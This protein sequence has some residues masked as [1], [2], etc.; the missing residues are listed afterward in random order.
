MPFRAGLPGGKAGVK[1]LDKTFLR[2]IMAHP[3]GGGFSFFLEQQVEPGTIKKF[4][5]IASSENMEK[6]I[7]D[8]P[9]LWDEVNAGI[10]DVLA[11]GRKEGLVD[12]MHSLDS[13]WKSWE[14]KIARSKNDPGLIGKAVPALIKFKMSK[15]AL[16]KLFLA[17]STGGPSG[18]I[19]F[20]FLN[21]FILNR[22]L[23]AHDLV[24]KPVNHHLFRLVWPF[25]TQ[26][27][28]LMPLV[29]RRGIYCFY[30]KKFVARL[31][32]IIGERPCLEVAAGDGALSV[33]LKGSGVGIT[34]TDDYSWGKSVA[35]PGQVEKLDAA[36]ALKKYHPEVVLCSWPPPV[37]RFEARI[38]ET[39]SVQH[40][41]VIGSRH[42][43]ASG[44]RR[45]YEEQKNFTM[46]PAPDLSS[47]ILPGENDNEVLIFSRK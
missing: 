19:R 6:I 8:Y 33:F 47:L 30:T 27:K 36:R 43:F 5:A 11:S 34:A 29:S 12:Y 26:K 46:A 35:Y 40:Y 25:I 37:N 2:H 13:S 31:T 38:F 24:R 4:N 3:R 45:A 18:K 39:P 15:Y 10:M 32:G 20:S 9:S 17:V 41:I 42:R 44:N 16:D 1:V 14:A 21:G 28:I 23:F 22:L 7:R